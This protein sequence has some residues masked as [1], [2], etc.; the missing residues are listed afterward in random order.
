MSVAI[1]HFYSNKEVKIYNGDSLKLIQTIPD[2]TVDLVVTSP[3][4]FMGKEYDRSKKVEDFIESHQALFP[5]IIRVTKKGGSIC[6]QVGYHSEKNVLIPLDYLIYDILKKHESLFLRNRIIWSFGHGLHAKYRFSGRHETVLWF[7]KGKDY[8]F[9]LDSVRIPQKYPGK[10][11]YKGEK[12]GEFSSNPLGKNPSD[13]WEIPNVNSNHIEK[14][15]HPCQ[16]PIALAQRLIKAL[17]PE[18]GIVFDPYMGSGSSCIAALLEKRKFIG[19][20]TE[21]NYC[22][23]A[24]ERILDFLDGKLIYRPLEQP[25]FEPNQNMAVAQKPINFK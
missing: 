21:L 2:E 24:K 18:G 16:F 3:P 10:R 22:T 5:E 14:T 20:D 17:T 1:E 25:I 7:S 4:Y 8:Y 6:W 11:H 12:K 9:D 23:I 19:A 15:E 13:V